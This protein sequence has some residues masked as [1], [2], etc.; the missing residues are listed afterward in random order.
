MTMTNMKMTNDAIH[1]SDDEMNEFD[2]VIKTAGPGTLKLDIALPGEVVLNPDKV[3]HVSPRVSGVA[4]EVHKSVGD[5]V[6]EGDLLAVLDSR[7]FA[8]SKAAFLATLAR[9][10]L[11]EAN[12]KRE[13][14]LWK[15]QITSRK[16]LA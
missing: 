10:R 7:E 3:A 6:S 8:R 16:K 1:L 14:K 9:E 5:P 4:R 15:D 12:F 11:A 13:T 2:I